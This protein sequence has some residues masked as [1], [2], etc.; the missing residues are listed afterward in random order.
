MRVECNTSESIKTTLCRGQKQDILFWKLPHGHP[1]VTLLC[2]EQL[3]GRR[4][5]GAKTT[6]LVGSLFLTS[7]PSWGEVTVWHHC[8]LPVLEEWWGEAQ[9][10]LVP[11]AWWQWSCMA[12][13]CLEESCRRG[14]W[15]LQRAVLL[16]LDNTCVPVQIQGFFSFAKGCIVCSQP[17]KQVFSISLLHQCSLLP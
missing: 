12:Q 17:R 7:T 8:R 3:A 4:K 5:E 2:G 6:W 16:S 15:P 9:E 14:G 1:S 11:P 13:P 10:S